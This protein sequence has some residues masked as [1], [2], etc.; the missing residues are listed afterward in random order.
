MAKSEDGKWVLDLLDEE[1]VPMPQ[2]I[3][4]ISLTLRF[5]CVCFMGGENF[6]FWREP[7]LHENVV[8]A[9]EWRNGNEGSREVPFVKWE[10]IFSLFPPLLLLE[11]CE[12]CFCYLWGELLTFFFF[13]IW[14]FNLS[15]FNFFLVLFIQDFLIEREKNISIWLFY[16]FRK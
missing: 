3:E 13:F 8:V 2:V 6:K 12:W 7:N 9:L 1:D 4:E 15:L 14:I 11:Q 16:F 5:C 10:K